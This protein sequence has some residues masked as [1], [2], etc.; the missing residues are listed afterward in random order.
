[1]DSN[2]IHNY[3]LSLYEL[4]D[5]A[6]DKKFEDDDHLRGLLIKYNGTPMIDFYIGQNPSKAR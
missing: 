3:L 5:V 6:Y 1:M 4:Y 2:T